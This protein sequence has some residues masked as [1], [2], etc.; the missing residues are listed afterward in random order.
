[1]LLPLASEG[2]HNCREMMAL[3]HRIIQYLVEHHGFNTVV[4]ESGL[5]ESRII[6]DYVLG[7]NSKSSTYHDDV[8]VMFQKGLNKMYGEWV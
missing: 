7:K 1:M 8:N 6:H 2:F 3:H 5:P 4:S